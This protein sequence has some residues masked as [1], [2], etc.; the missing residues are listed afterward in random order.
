MPWVVGASFAAASAGMAEMAPV[1][2][3]VM[4]PVTMRPANTVLENFM[5]ITSFSLRHLSG[6]TS[7]VGAA[8]MLSP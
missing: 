3:A 7:V 6:P 2:P 5:I 8:A 1:T 4:R